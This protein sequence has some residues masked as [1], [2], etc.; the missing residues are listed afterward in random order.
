MGVEQVFKGTIQAGKVIQG[1]AAR[2]TDRIDIVATPTGSEQDSGFDLPKKGAVRA[3]WV[4]VTTAEATGTT[5][6]LD[7]GLLA[8]ESG[9]D[10]N[11]FLV[12]VDVSSTGLQKGTLL[13]TGQTLG[14][15][16]SVDEDGA[17]ALVP[18][19]HTLNGT[20]RSVSFTAA[21]GDWAEFRGTIYVEYM[22]L[23]E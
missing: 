11:G 5:K 21:S 3:V 19:D 23:D 16:L 10:A 8:S 7:V 15:L 13:N 22:D 9:G 6:T 1:G 2:T 4:D 14:A 20:A 17:G 12:A 18:E